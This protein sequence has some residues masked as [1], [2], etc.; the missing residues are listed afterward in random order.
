MAMNEAVTCPTVASAASTSPL[1]RAA[2]ATTALPLAV[3]P[4]LGVALPLVTICTSVRM[5]PASR[6]SW[7]EIQGR[8][9]GGAGE[10][11]ARCRRDVG[12]M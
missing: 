2:A 9:R 1:R 3:A 5:R 12:E 8:C 6:R 4:P 11:Q 10:M 7:R